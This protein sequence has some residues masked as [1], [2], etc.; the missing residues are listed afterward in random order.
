MTSKQDH[1][2]TPFSQSLTTVGRGTAEDSKQL[3]GK[4]L[5]CSV[6]QVISSG[7]VE[8][9]FEVQVGA[10]WTLPKIQIPILY[11]EYIRYPIQ[12]GDKGLA[13]AADF[14]LGGL[15][16]L[17]SGVPSLT[18]LPG[19]LSCL[20][21]LWLGSSSWSEPLDPNSVE[22]YGVGDKGVILHDGGSTNTLT[23]DGDG[24]NLNCTAL[25]VFGTAPIAQKTVSGDLSGSTDTDLKG[26]VQSLI[27]ALADYG[28][29]V[30]GTT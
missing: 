1:L 8:I 23:V 5:P 16:G 13:L 17:G 20:A 26:V 10:P 3:S 21:F 30:D 18:D 14:R 4:S 2:K 12:V 29:I 28:I 22:I 24:M 27:D 11:P 9:N 19:N 7:I 15:S 25:G 6:S